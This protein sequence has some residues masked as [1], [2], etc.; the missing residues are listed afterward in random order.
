MSWTLQK[1]PKRRWT[2]ELWGH[3]S[4]TSGQSSPCLKWNVT[5]RPRGC[6]AWIL[7]TKATYSWGSE[8]S[9]REERGAASSGETLPTNTMFFSY[10]VYKPQTM[11][12][13][14]RPS[15]PWYSL[16]VHPYSSD[17]FPGWSAWWLHVLAWVCTGLPEPQPLLRYLK[18]S[19]DIRYQMAPVGWHL[20]TSFLQ[21]LLF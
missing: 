15:L 19:K 7:H 20:R 14:Q 6:A 4:M 5:L 9:L 17:I 21:C 16:I 1:R 2:S 3:K 13:R 18:E 12:S 11:K 8:S 10:H